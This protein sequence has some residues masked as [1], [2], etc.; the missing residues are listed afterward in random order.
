MSDGGKWAA[1]ELSANGII[2]N[3]EPGF[4]RLLFFEGLPVRHGFS[5]RK[6]G[7]SS[8][9]FHSLNLGLSVGDDP[10]AVKENRR[11]YFG[12]LGLHP[13]H[14]VRVRQ[15]HGSDVLVVDEALAGREGFPR[16][17]LDEEYRYDALLTNLPGLGLCISTADCLP[18]FLMDPRRR[19]IGAVH[20]G[21]RSSVRG[22][23]EQAVRKMTD[24]YDTDPADC[25]AAIGPGVRGC[26]YEVDA[27]VI[28]PLKAAFA[29]WETC[30]RPVKEDRWMLDL[31]AFNV[32]IL[33]QVG[34]RSDRIFDT[35]LC[36]ACRTDLFYSHRAEKPT[37]GRM[38]S[39]IALTD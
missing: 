13:A 37:T 22:I 26:C 18:I 15:V 16:L 7:V 12:A 19:V 27:P 33:R 39:L 30:V 24:T 8:P 1:M 5:T 38:M 35:R 29:A 25:Y 36:T 21:W 10:A 9:P 28:T 34:L 6:G 23:T 2:E 31:A 3:R 4:L 17:L 14:V 32:S 20:A 11:R